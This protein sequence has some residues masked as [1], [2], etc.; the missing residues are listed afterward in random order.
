MPTNLISPLVRDLQRAVGERNVLFAPEDLL[1]YEY[2]A[3]IE[4]ALPDV[5]VFPD[6]ADE[7][8]AVVRVAHAYDQP[9]VPRGSGTGLA[10]GT[11]PVRGG[12]VVALTRMNRIVEIDAANRIAIVEPGVINLDLQTAVAKHGLLYAPDPSS[13]R[14]CTLGGNVANNSGGPHTLAHGS[15]SSP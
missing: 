11:V 13:Q 7:V 10:G 8:A 4:R 9:I 1:V 3:T 6:T 2:D 14:I 15:T 12:I 5:V